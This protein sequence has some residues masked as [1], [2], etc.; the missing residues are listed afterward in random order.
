KLRH[1][2]AW[3]E[4]RR[5]N[6]VLYDE[7]LK[8]SGV[9]IPRAIP[10]VRHV[11]HCYTIR[12]AGR[13]RVQAELAANGIQTGVHYPIPIHLQPAYAGLGYSCGDFPVSETAADEVLALPIHAD[14]TELQIRQV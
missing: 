7:L 11:W 5:T 6:A 13:E 3:T 12:V 14:L 4:A 10:G 9:V 2:E 8:G 1:L